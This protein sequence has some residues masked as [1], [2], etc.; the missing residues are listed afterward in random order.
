[1]T[2][3]IRGGKVLTG[4]GSL[5]AVDIL[6]QGER[7]AAVGPDLAAPPDVQVL[8]ASGRIIVPG[9]INAHTHAH[10]NLTRGLAG[11]W[12]LEELLAHVP[13]ALAGRTAEDH[14]LSAALGAIEMLK[15][16]CTAA[17]DL[18]AT[19][20][21]PTE[22]AIDAAARAHI[23][24]G[25]R[26]VIAPTVADGVFYPTVPGL[27]HSLPPD[28]RR[29]VA[30]ME[31]LPQERLLDLAR[32]TIRRWDGA[33][34]GRIRA[35]VAPAI[36]GQCSDDLLV[37]CARLAREYGVGFHTHL[38]ESKVQVIQA[39][40][41]WGTTIV[42]RLSA[43]GILGP[44]FV[45]AHAIWLTEEDIR[46]LG[47][48]GARVVHNPGSNLRTGSGIAPVRE[49][50]E[51]GVTVGL[52]TDGVMCSDN[53]NLFEAMRLA[54]LVATV[55]SPH[56][57]VGWLSAE[58]VWE[59]ATAGSAQVLGMA[60]SLG[61]IAAGRYADLVLL[62]ANSVYLCPTAKLLHALVY[63]E[64]GAS[65]ETVLVGGRVVVEGGRVL[66][67][68]EESLRRRAQAATDRILGANVELRAFAER[69]SP[70]IRAA[71][72]SVAAEPYAVN[73]YAVPVGG[74]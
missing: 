54:A 63:A 43:M 37:A 69:I 42:G 23:D 40:R 46:L 15:S 17:Y 34:G 14:Y 48:T 61:A 10:N 51:A 66:T 32:Y 29:V 50:L 57:P 16:G 73:R 38:A 2:L 60:D 4:A 49:L 6:V 71:C 1:M 18:F 22:E 30:G 59:M 56:E 64:T 72:R 8:D 35:A 67:V 68:D 20:P 28:L 3:L 41:R 13:A 39:Q 47:A 27:F 25:L 5:E 45:G 24:V 7:I 65:V 53:L 36:P 70:Y 33:A 62:R 58:A 26:A 44:S 11:T 12:V 21:L 19:Y 55:R 52:G 74:A 31:P 9:L